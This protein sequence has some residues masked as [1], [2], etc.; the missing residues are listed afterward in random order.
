MSYP[1]ER[2]KGSVKGEGPEIAGKKDSQK[3]EG[4]SIGVFARTCLHREKKKVREV[5][6]QRKEEVKNL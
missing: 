5:R 4:T 1:T 6:L 3:L 2:R